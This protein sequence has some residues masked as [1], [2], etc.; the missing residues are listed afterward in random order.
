MCIIIRYDIVDDENAPEALAR[1]FDRR[2]RALLSCGNRSRL[3]RCANAGRDDAEP[4]TAEMWRVELRPQY[5]AD[6]ARLP[7]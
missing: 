6:R 2:G 5:V 3:R 7:I 1:H 4:N